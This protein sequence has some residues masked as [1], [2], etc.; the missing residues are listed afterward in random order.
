MT[1]LFNNPQQMRHLI[2]NAACRRRIGMSD[3]LVEL[4]DAQGLDDLLLFF[5]VSDHAP[6]ILNLDLPAFCNFYFLC[7]CRN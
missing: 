4:C 2:N 3:R 5:R 6:V 1:N 7:H